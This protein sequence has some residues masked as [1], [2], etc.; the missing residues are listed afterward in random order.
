MKPKIDRETIARVVVYAV[1]A[2]FWVYVAS[3]VISLF[4]ISGGIAACVLGLVIYLQSRE[5]YRLREKVHRL[6]LI[7]KFHER[8][9]K[10]P[11]EAD[12]TGIG[13]EEMQKREL[14]EMMDKIRR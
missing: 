2:G 11:T 10:A 13:W 7:Q 12:L 6:E 14:K 4:G 5:N 9:Q 1:C 3:E 8:T